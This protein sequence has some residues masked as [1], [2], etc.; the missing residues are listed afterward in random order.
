MEETEVWLRK[1]GRAKALPYMGSGGAGL[2]GLRLQ[3]RE[4]GSRT[5]YAEKLCDGSCD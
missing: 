5:P 4:L 3:K 2:A 1:T